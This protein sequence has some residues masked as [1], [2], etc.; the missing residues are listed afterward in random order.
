MC[1]P[2]PVYF[3]PRRIEITSVKHSCE[4]PSMN[5]DVPARD[6][7]GQT[8]FYAEKSPVALCTTGS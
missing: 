5:D 7:E 2:G 6:A 4:I 8:S 3:G 1:L